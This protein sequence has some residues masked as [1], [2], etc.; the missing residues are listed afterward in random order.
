MDNLL[1]ACFY[2]GHRNGKQRTAGANI[3]DWG[4][5]NHVSK[6]EK[7]SNRRGKERKRQLKRIE[8][9]LELSTFKV[10]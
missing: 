1:S 5:K 8:T 3:E 10:E 9:S 4:K 7:N 2:Q 6:Q